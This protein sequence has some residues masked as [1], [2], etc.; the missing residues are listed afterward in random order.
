MA[1]I[2]KSTTEGT[3][4]KFIN[5]GVV[6]FYENQLELIGINV[7]PAM[8][9]IVENTQYVYKDTYVNKFADVEVIRKNDKG[10][11]KKVLVKNGETFIKGDTRKFSAPRKL[12]E[13]RDDVDVDAL[14]LKAM[15]F[16]IAKANLELI[17]AKTSAIANMTPT[18]NL[19]G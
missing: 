15:E 3:F 16:Q 14:S 19:L 1:K 13:F 12:A 11:D 2:T 6:F 9:N 7:T 18:A 10:E 17:K 5:E 8:L 4:V